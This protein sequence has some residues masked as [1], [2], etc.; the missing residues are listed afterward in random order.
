MSSAEMNEGLIDELR[1]E[2]EQRRRQLAI[3]KAIAMYHML[4]R[5]EYALLETRSYAE[6]VVDTK[7]TIVPTNMPLLM[8]MRSEHMPT[9]IDF[10]LR[11]M[12][13]AAMG[14][15][16]ISREPA[17]RLSR[18]RQ[19]RR[20]LRT[21]EIPPGRCT[22]LSRDS[23]KMYEAMPEHHK[24]AGEPKLTKRDLLILL[25]HYSNARAGRDEELDSE[26]QLHTDE[27]Y[28]I[29]IDSSQH[30]GNDEPSEDMGNLSLE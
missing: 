3:A 23:I 15:G 18:R 11:G 21:C 6:M 1:A 17:E 19:V 26:E 7:R 8:A 16:F 10:V 20:G 27:S 14:S 12:F 2:V 9:G 4:L 25:Y 13:L 22:L 5:V 28:E 29:E 30:P 24:R